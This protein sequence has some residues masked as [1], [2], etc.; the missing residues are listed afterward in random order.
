MNNL[1][2]SDVFEELTWRGALANAT[3][4][5]EQRLKTEK[6]TC[7]TGFDP[8]SDT[9]HIGNLLP[10]L[11]L[12]RMQRHGHTPIAILGGGTGMIG[13]PSGRADERSLLS[14]EQ[15][16]ENAAKIRIQLEKF[17]DFGAKT[18]P[19][20]LIN[21]AD[22][23]RPANLIEFLRDIGKHFTVNGML[24]RDSVRSR[25]ERGGGMSFTEF[26]YALL[27][28]YDF[29]MLFER[30]DCA[31]QS[32]GSDQWGNILDGVNLIRR[33][34]GARPDESSHA[35]GIVFP[36]IIDSKGDKLGK[37]I[38]G[39]PALDPDIFSPYR[40]YQYFF[41]TE[42]ADVIRYLKF[43]TWLGPDEIV[44]LEHGVAEDPGRRDAQRSL[45]REV[46]AIVHGESGLHQAERVTRAFF[47][48]QFADL[49][50]DEIQDVFEGS[51][52][53][54]ILKSD[55]ENRQLRFEQIAVGSRLVS[56]L[57]EARRTT[58][59]GGMYINSERVYDP[60]RVITPDDLL[61]GNIIVLRR[62]QREH[63]LITVT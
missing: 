5:A 10:L 13:D 18:N 54:N 38:G 40:L 22:W 52:S 39:A 53:T 30:E 21:N 26:S 43:L 20:K 44:P 55:I 46:T 15:I 24:Q 23:L 9:L 19:A 7:Y 35:H 45:A 36:L 48:G 47:N 1:T 27:Q 63:R 29:L 14:V 41:N 56:S 16:D 31:F 12:A 2:F 59:Q 50:A 42:D 51:S 37:S 60:A 17:L 8:T 49:S 3:T 25:K 62:G 4:G 57:G 61:H 58:E 34:H 11:C 28:A 6:I 32:G 33:K